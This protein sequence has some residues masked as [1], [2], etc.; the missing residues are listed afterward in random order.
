MG[1]RTLLPTRTRNSIRKTLVI[2]LHEGI[3]GPKYP[4]ESFQVLEGCEDIGS[5][6]GPDGRRVRPLGRLSKTPTPTYR[7]LERNGSERET[8]FVSVVPSEY[9][10]S[11]TPTRI[12]LRDSRSKYHLSQLSPIGRSLWSSV[13]TNTP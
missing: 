8:T 3:R 7:G 11:P 5:T 6:P 10:N 2:R 13:V 1:K 12:P 4:K 9:I